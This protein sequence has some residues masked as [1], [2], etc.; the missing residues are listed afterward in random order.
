MAYEGDDNERDTCAKRC[1]GFGY[2]GVQGGTQCW[3]GHY[4]PW[5]RDILLAPQ[6]CDLKCPGNTDQPCGGS[7]NKMDVYRIFEDQGSSS[8]LYW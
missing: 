3:C 7:N 2:A 6:E 5:G 8:E 4:T 1:M